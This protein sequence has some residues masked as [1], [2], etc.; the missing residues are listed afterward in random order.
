M[1]KKKLENILKALAN[2]RRLSIIS[3]LKSLAEDNVG[4][5]ART[6]KLS[7][8]ATSRHLVRLERAGIL[9]KEQRDKEVF[10]RLPKHAVPFL[11]YLIAEL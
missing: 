11:R 5:I 6:I 4:N 3:H 2:H 7:L 9:E 1:G 10:Y 8:A